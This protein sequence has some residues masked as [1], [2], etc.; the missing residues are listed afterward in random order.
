M[1][2]SSSLLHMNVLVVS[3]LH[4]DCGVICNSAILILTLLHVVSRHCCECQH[5]ATS[6]SSLMIRIESSIRHFMRIGFSHYRY[7]ACGKGAGVPIILHA[8]LLRFHVRG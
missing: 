8:A 4:F 1:T 5:S 7:G 2:L 6:I 3:S